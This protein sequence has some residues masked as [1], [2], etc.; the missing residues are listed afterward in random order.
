MCAA[1]VA[2]S[3]DTLTVEA[4]KQ[5]GYPNATAGDTL[6]VRSKIWFEEFKGIVW[7]ASK[8]KLKSLITTY[9]HTIGTGGVSGEGQAVRNNPSDFAKHISMTLLSGLEPIPGTCQAGDADAST[10]KLAVGATLTTDM[11][12]KEIFLF[13]NPEPY[14]VTDSS[15]IVKI[16]DTTK[17]VTVAP[18]FTVIVDPTTTTHYV[19][20]S[21]VSPITKGSIWTYDQKRESVAPGTPVSFH[22]IMNT[23]ASLATINQAGQFMLFP[24]PY[25]G[26]SAIRAIR[27]RYFANLTV[28]DNDDSA[29]TKIMGYLLNKWRAEV[30]QFIKYKALDSDKDPRAETE[31]QLFFEVMLPLLV[32]EEQKG[33]DEMIGTAPTVSLTPTIDQ[34]TVEAIKQASIEDIVEG[35]TLQKR[36]EIWL[37]ECLGE[38]WKAGSGKLRSMMA[39]KLTGITTTDGTS[40]MEGSAI[41]DNPS[42]F[43]SH[44]GM[45]LLEGIHYG[46]CQAGTD[47]NTMK[48]A[49]DEDLSASDAIGKEI[50]VFLTEVTQTSLAESAYIRNFNET[51]KI[52]E[53]HS[54]FAFT[55]GTTHSYLVVDQIS[56]IKEGNVWNYDDLRSGVRRGQPQSYHPMNDA[57]ST[58]SINTIVE[59]GQ[60]ALSPIPYWN[61]DGKL[62]ALRHRYYANLLKIDIT[63]T[64][65]TNIFA[66]LLVDWQIEFTQYIKYKAMVEV[67][68]EGSEIITENNTT[69]EKAN[70]VTVNDIARELT[71]WKNMKADLIARETYGMDFTNLNSTVDDGSRYS[72]LTIEI[73]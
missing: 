21:S 53:L 40:N 30:T 56:D 31:K 38:I 69:R 18:D 70:S 34:I 10:V 35:D 7:K 67:S 12:G 73:N 28:L 47:G 71:I 39:R 6:Q 19:V 72:G 68:L 52:A 59:G 5:A 60:F 22:P 49:S 20:V 43:A 32:A 4:L 61:S 50:V 27:Q 15:F 46:V 2:P 51:T 58:S 65:Q 45:T 25:F 42:D 11:I 37:R 33:L 14:N 63:D 23:N 54:T 44:I 55:P 66:K 9:N 3:I 17:L 29:L 48:L 16:D 26:D 57:D 36:S 62:R 64:A 41:Q 8:G 13:E 24:S 1:P